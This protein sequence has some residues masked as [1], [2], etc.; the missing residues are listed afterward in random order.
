MDVCHSVF[1]WLPMVTER[2]VKKGATSYIYKSK[3]KS[4]TFVVA[5][6]CIHYSV[7]SYT[8]KT[9]GNTA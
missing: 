6:T 8:G 7:M 4:L 1:A 5:D 9:H 2:H 3:I